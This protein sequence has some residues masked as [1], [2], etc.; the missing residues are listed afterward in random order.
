MTDGKD[1]NLGRRFLHTHSIGTPKQPEGSP[2]LRFLSSHERSLR[3]DTRTAPYGA[4]LVFVGCFQP[5]AGRAT[6]GS[7]SCFVYRRKTTGV[8]R[9]SLGRL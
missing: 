3:T 6:T 1:N 7:S 4:V 9:L 2:S 8:L 5:N